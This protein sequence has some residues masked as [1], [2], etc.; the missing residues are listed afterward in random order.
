MTTRAMG[1][2]SGSKPRPTLSG[3]A[4][5]LATLA[6]QAIGEN[7]GNISSISNNKITAMAG[8]NSGN[9]APNGI[10]TAAMGEEGTKPRPLL[11]GGGNKGSITTMAMGEE[12]RPTGGGGSGITTLPDGTPYNPGRPIPGRPPGGGPTPNQTTSS[13]ATSLIDSI[14]TNPT[15]PTGTQISPQLQN[16]SANELMTT[17]GVTGTVAAATPTTTAAPTITGAA[18]PT[19]TDTTIPTAQTAAQST[20][21]QVAGSTPTMAGAQGSL[22]AGSIAQGAQGAISSDATVRGQLAGLQSDVETAVASGKPLP[23]WARGAAKA[24]EAAMANR[25]MSQSSWQLKH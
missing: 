2:E 3:A 22:S 5:T 12:G 11:I 21:T 18:A 1:E 25:G 20:A 13:K 8:E 16:V 9:I 4:G 10:T 23:V 24:T 14:I 17:P 15:M 19:S 6:T 7:S